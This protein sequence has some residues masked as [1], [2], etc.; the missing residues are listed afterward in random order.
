MPDSVR[1][2][3]MTLVSEYLNE[4]LSSV[5]G[6]HRPTA[7]GMHP[8]IRESV[9]HWLMLND[10]IDMPLGV[11]TSDVC[12][13]MINCKLEKMHLMQKHESWTITDLRGVFL[14]SAPCIVMPHEV[15]GQAHATSVG[16]LEGKE[17]L[18]GRERKLLCTALRVSTQGL[19]KLLGDSP[20][21]HD[22]S[23]YIQDLLGGSLKLADETFRRIVIDGV[24]YVAVPLIETDYNYSTLSIKGITFSL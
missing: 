1:F 15:V 12:H 14:A 7:A 11:T 18:Q 22:D 5:D 16:L 8:S 19:R 9:D 13:F 21:L 23:P 3:I 4:L 2:S 6:K 20:E 24:V 17:D 10:G